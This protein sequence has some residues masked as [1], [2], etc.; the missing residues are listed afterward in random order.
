[1]TGSINLIRS[2]AIMYTK[3]LLVVEFTLNRCPIQ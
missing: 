2:Q 3:M 1:M